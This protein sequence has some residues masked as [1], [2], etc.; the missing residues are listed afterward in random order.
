[1]KKLTG[2]CLCGAISYEITGELGAIYNC[3][4]SKCRRW[5]GAAFRT[6]ASVKSSSFKWLSGEEHLSKYD[7]S[8]NITKTFCRICGSALIS[9]IKDNPEFIGLPLGGLEED[10]GTRTIANIFVSSK[11]P[12]YEI[13]DGIPQYDKWPP[14]GPS[15]VRAK[16]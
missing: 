1:M 5:H 13:T 14:D 4:C 16:S 8:D 7:S 12:W 10:P 11:A 15:S 9:L 2:K 6:R 3:H